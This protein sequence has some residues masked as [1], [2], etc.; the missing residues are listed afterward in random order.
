[1]KRLVGGA[2]FVLLLLMWQYVACVTSDGELHQALHSVRSVV[3]AQTSYSR[4]NGGWF[5][6]NLTCLEQ[7][8]LCRAGH[9]DAMQTGASVERHPTGQFFPGPAVPKGEIVSA[10]ASP[11]SIRSFVYLVTPAERAPWW[12]RYSAVPLPR[13]FCGDDRGIVCALPA[14]FRT[15]AP[16]QACPAQCRE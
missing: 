8:S 11:S 13:S 12:A 3:V 4:A 16:L 6:S 7:P 10:G 5:E 9:S 14:D 2:G 15:S 1:M